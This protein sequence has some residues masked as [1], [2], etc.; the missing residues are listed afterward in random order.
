MKSP[1]L[2]IDIITLPEQ[3]SRND[4]LH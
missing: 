2:A 4:W 3:S 1:L